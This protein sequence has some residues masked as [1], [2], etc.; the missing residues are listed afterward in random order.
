[1]RHTKLASLTCFEI[2]K[3]SQKM[4]TSIAQKKV[5]SKF[6]SNFAFD[7]IS[8]EKDQVFKSAVSRGSE[9]FQSI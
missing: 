3:E 5:L 7:F 8:Y 2:G 6:V 4:L 9:G 1:M